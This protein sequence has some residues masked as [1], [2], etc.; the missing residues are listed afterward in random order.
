M[1][2]LL[3]FANTGPAIADESL[4]VPS[5]PPR[6]ISIK[7]IETMFAVSPSSPEVDPEYVKR[8][9]LVYFADIPVMIAICE[10]ES[11]FEHYRPDGTLNVNRMVTKKGKRVSSASGAC[12]ITYLSHYNAWAESEETN[13]TTIE[14]NFAF[15]RKMYKESGTSPWIESKASCWGSKIHKY[16]LRV[17][18]N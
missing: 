9:A 13:I 6:N 14:G 3:G 18:S 4:S 15:A 10:C 8:L 7:A 5:V 11:K 16:D 2:C 1:I 17:A 12:Q